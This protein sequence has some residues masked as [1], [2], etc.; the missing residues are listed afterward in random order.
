MSFKKTF[1]EKGYIIIKNFIDEDKIN[2]VFDELN[3]TIDYTINN[4]KLKDMDLDQKYNYL[5]ENNDELRKHF[6]DLIGKNYLLQSIWNSNKL[7][8]ILNNIN[9][10]VFF[11]DGIQIRIDSNK[12]DRILPMHQERGQI[13]TNEITGWLPFID[14]DENSGGVKII[15]KSHILGDLPIINYGNYTGVEEKYLISPK[16]ILMNKGDLLLFHTD[17]IHG[18]F[19]NVNNKIRWVSVCRFNP[20]NNIP[21]LRNSNSKINMGKN[22]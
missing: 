12:N 22:L 7:K 3:K 6:Y 15:E 19:P 11:V 17:L 21:Y 1:E 16:K 14:I 13:S 18:S 5:A 10:D 8:D 20:L 2:K 4:L 9:N